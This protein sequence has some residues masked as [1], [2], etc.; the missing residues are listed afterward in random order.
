MIIINHHSF[1][2]IYFHESSDST[3]E[4]IYVLLNCSFSDSVIKILFP[5][6]QLRG[7]KGT[8]GRGLS[9]GNKG[10]GLSWFISSILSI[11]EEI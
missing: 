8:S 1:L 4:L 3:G 9:I 6:L 11:S 10:K 2:L 5:S 7:D